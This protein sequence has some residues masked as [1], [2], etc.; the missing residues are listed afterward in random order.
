IRRGTVAIAFA[1][2]LAFVP[3][4]HAGPS[5]VTILFSRSEITTANRCVAD[6][7]NAVRLD[8][9]VLPWLH[10]IGYKATGTVE[11]GPT[12]QSSMYCTHSA[13][14]LAASW[15]QLTAFNQKYGFQPVS[16]S[17]TYPTNPPLSQL[18]PSRQYSE[19]CGSLQDLQNHGFRRGD[20]LFA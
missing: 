8:T 18:S 12:K 14:T 1:D 5:Y 7:T 20:G 13:S 17:R 6:G 3:V 16:H 11:T 2:S 19:T 10:Q 15:N 9:T 4:A